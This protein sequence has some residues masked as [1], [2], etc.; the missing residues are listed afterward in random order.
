MEKG[1]VHGN[2]NNTVHGITA[3]WF[4]DDTFECKERNCLHNN[5]VMRERERERERE[6]TRDKVKT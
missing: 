1:Y 4:Y 5:N 6:R 3:R 2:W